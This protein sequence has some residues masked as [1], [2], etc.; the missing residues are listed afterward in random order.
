M[1]TPLKITCWNIEHAH[2]LVSGASNAAVAERRARI[3]RTLTAIDPDILCVVE[4]PAG[5]ARIR[6]FAEEVLDNAWV[7]IL[8]ETDNGSDREYRM[9][10]TQWIWFLVRSE[11]VGQCALQAPDVWQSFTGQ[12][13][14]SVHDWGRCAP[15]THQHYR[16]PQVL[17]LDIGQDT[18]LELIGIHLK[19][20][21]NLQ[22]IERDAEGNLTGAYLDEAL[23]ARVKLAT[24]AM[25]VRKYI[26]AK[27]AQKPAPGILVMG[28]ANDGPGHDVFES[29]YL[30]FDLVSNLQG[31]VLRAERFFNH[32]LFDYPEHLRW[33]A[34]YGDPLTG[35]SAANNPLLID[36]IMISQA[37]CRGALPLVAN[38]HAG[39]VEHEAFERANAG[40]GSARRTSDH[41]PVSLRLDAR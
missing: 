35:F 2:R 37:L 28:D 22:R 1:R 15:Q 30:F 8:L 17:I 36:H 40:A 24:E 10:G 23:R 21:I 31:D 13:R 12:T 38:A 27:F 3:H 6:Q 33:T 16:H 32:A 5:V 4:G 7:P 20:K 25:D 26:D 19:S 41:R 11:L 34:R 14:W 9:S 29:H 18:Q 39:Q